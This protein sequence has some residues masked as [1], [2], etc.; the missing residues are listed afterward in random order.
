MKNRIQKFKKKG[1]YKRKR[2]TQKQ[3]RDIPKSGLLIQYV[4]H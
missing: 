4:T 1:I 3:C 2:L